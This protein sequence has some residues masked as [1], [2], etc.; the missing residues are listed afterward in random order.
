[1]A[2]VGRKKKKV[3]ALE[4]LLEDNKTIF[5]PGQ[6]VEG[7]HLFPF[8]F[9]LPSIRLPPS[10]EGDYGMIRYEI[11]CFLDRPG[12]NP[13]HT[14]LVITVPCTDDAEDYKEPVECVA[15][16]GSGSLWWKS[17]HVECRALIPRRGV[18]SEDYLR[19]NL[20]IRNHSAKGVHIKDLRLKQRVKYQLYGPPGFT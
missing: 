2:I 3:R 6:R 10:F 5:L 18:A 16:A 19:L 14:T 20:E 9:R 8:S 13:K 11:V 15:R 12:K 17:G 4:L 7:E 1:M